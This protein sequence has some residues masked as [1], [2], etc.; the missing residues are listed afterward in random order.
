MVLSV[1]GKEDAPSACQAAAHLPEQSR[2]DFLRPLPDSAARR[3]P[4]KEDAL[5]HVPPGRQG[6]ADSP[7]QAA[8]KHRWALPPSSPGQ[9]AQTR[10]KVAAAAAA[11]WLLRLRKPPCS[12]S[13]ASA[14]S[15]GPGSF[16][17]QPGAPSRT[18]TAAESWEHPHRSRAAGAALDSPHR[19]CRAPSRSRL[20]GRAPRWRQGSPGLRSA[21]SEDFTRPPGPSPAPASPR[22]PGASPSRSRGR[23]GG[24]R[25]TQER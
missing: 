14:R 15:D 25:G 5:C 18:A 11:A 3:A 13:S 17:A 6:R 2:E 20:S 19:G 4:R 8:S 12:T 1:A 22:P 7:L 10:E 23:A 16:L 9:A 21:G 24:G